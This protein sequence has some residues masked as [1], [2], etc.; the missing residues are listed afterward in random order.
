MSR[1]TADGDNQ[2]SRQKTPI[3]WRRPR[4]HWCRRRGSRVSGTRPAWVKTTQLGRGS[5]S[6]VLSR[7][8]L[9]RLARGLQVHG[10]EP[11]TAVSV[12]AVDTPSCTGSGERRCD[13]VSGACRG[14]GG[15]RLRAEGRTVERA[16][17]AA[18]CER[19]MSDLFRADSAAGPK[20]MGA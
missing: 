9:E 3:A 17:K 5:G 2:E 1:A 11:S 12:R 13:A 14:D 10:H 15:R 20:A 16:E 19:A 4:R 8:A 18:R 7:V 6:C